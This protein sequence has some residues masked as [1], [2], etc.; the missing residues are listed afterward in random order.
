[1][2][3]IACVTTVVAAQDTFDASEQGSQDTMEAYRAIFL[4]HTDI[5]AACELDPVCIYEKAKNV[6]KTTDNELMKTFFN[7]M[8]S[9]FEINKEAI[10]AMEEKCAVPELKQTRTAISD[11]FS[12]LID[13]FEKQ[14][15]ESVLEKRLNTCLAEKLQKPAQ[16]DNPFAIGALMDVY[17][18]LG[19]EQSHQELKDRMKNLEGTSLYKLYE[20]CQQEG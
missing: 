18:N 7:E 13:S 1:M 12:V 3:F 20:V 16:G 2:L 6:L 11:C 19:N 8:V 14:E 15:E 10:M 9:E 17:E 4:T 5:T